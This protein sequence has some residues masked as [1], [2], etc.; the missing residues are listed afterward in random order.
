M[1]SLDSVAH[2]GWL[3]DDI[4]VTVSRYVPSVLILSNNLNQAVVTIRGP[5]NR[6]ERGTY[7][8]IT[9]VPPGSFEF[10]YGDVPY[11]TKPALKTLDLA[12]GGTLVVN[13]AYGFTD[14]NANGISDAWEQTFLGSV[15]PGNNGLGDADFDGATDRAEF[16]S[17][18]NPTNALSRLSLLPP[19][20]T[21]SGDLLLRWESSA[22]RAYQLQGSADAEFWA[23]LSVWQRA[24]SSSYSVT[25]PAPTNG[26]PY[27]YRLEVRP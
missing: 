17:G 25:I 22:G 8:V 9:N 4:S 27:L 12:E 18:T 15:S 2:P 1:L 19:Q 7:T 10:E 14:T 23:P 5:M 20:P 26:A 21:A 16:M 11:Y 3:V 6:T 13:G 24:A